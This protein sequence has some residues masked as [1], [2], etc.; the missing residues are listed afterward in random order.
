[1]EHDLPSIKSWKSLVKR[2]NNPQEGLLQGKSSWKMKPV[3]AL[4]CTLLLIFWYK[5]T[6]IQYQ[7]TQ[8]EET[9]YPF[10]MAKESEPV[11]EKLKGLPFG[12]I[13]PRSDLE[14]KPLWSSTSLRSKGGELTNRNL[15]AMPVGLKQKDNVNAVV[16]KFLPA[17]FTVILFHYDGNMD[18]WW[19]LEWSSKAIHIVA[20]NQTKWWFAKRF[21]HPDI[22]SIY[23]YVFLWDE[24]LGVEN[25]NPQ[26]YLKIVKKAGLEISQ[27]ALHPNSTEVHHRITVRSRTNVFH[28]R[29][30]DSRGNMKCS[31]T[32]EGPPCTGFVEGMAPV[33]SRSA[34]FCT[35]NLIQNDLVHGWGMDM[36]LGYCAQGDRSKKVGIVDSEYIFHQGIQTLGGSGYPDK[37]NSARSGVTRRRGSATFDSRTEIR[38]QSTW[39]LRT[40]KERWNR[41]VE[42]DKNWIDRS[43]STRNRISNNRRF[44]RSSVI[45]SLLQ[46][47]AEETRK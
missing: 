27:P 5:T 6:N 26:K 28:R 4:M 38:R 24:D 25:F 40:F 35:W 2:R 29:V 47:Q 16:Q 9:D 39:E 7:Q 45:S 15:L 13:Q 22:V 42:E 10:E 19:D 14:L 34:W 1:M 21:L 33:F 18:Q 37:K 36:K 20:H 8:I 43:S 17:N 3:M 32:S 46:S 44:K 41:A 11:S 12:I 31:N 30:Y 23:D